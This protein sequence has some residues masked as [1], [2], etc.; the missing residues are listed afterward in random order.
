MTGY[1]FLHSIFNF[2]LVFLI[3]FC[4]YSVGLPYENLGFMALRLHL[5][6]VHSC[7]IYLDLYL[8]TIKKYLWKEESQ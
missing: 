1:K 4:L 5:P 6:F 7:I 2:F 8:A 3:I